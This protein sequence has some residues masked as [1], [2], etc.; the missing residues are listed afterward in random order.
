MGKQRIAG[1]F[2]D[3]AATWWSEIR[4][5]VTDAGTVLIFF[6]AVIL[7]PM[8]YSVGY[9]RET[10]RGIPV[11][12]VDLDQTVTSRRLSRLLD[13]TEQV[14][15]TCKPLNLKEAED[16]FYRGEV[17]GVLLIPVSFEKKILKGEQTGTTIY[18]DAGRFF[19][20]KQVYTAASYAAGMMNAGVEIRSMLAGGKS[21]NE[22]LN[23]TAGISP[24]FFDLYNPSSGYATFIVPCIL[25]IVIQQSLLVG[26][27]LLSGKRNERKRPDN[28]GVN[29]RSPSRMAGIL[30]KSMAY[31]SLYLLTTL[32]TL[33]L[34]YHWLSFPEKT[35]FTAI[36]PVLILFLFTVSFMGL[37]IGSWFTKRAHALMFVI[38]ISPI[39]FFLSG[40]PWPT[41]S[42]PGV[43]RFLSLFFPSTPMLP[44]FLKLRLIGGGIAA[45]RPEILLLAVQCLGWFFVAWLTDVFVTFRRKPTPDGSAGN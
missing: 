38:F 31:V 33:V 14:D 37:A 39:V 22:A 24:Q 16:L 17:H 10:I 30:G 29:P 43:T 42:M 5:S 12:V 21:W 13:A 18:C 32:V 35:N 6:V 8:L 28:P 23:R 20:Y 45:I 9:L 4:E 15:V 25:I 41:Q 44:A 11:A 26:I 34:F 1:F 3:T 2:N 19:V 27:G 36:Y 7:Y 40:V